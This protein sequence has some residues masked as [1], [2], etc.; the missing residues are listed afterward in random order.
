MLSGWLQA[1]NK[2]LTIMV[3]I[4]KVLYFLTTMVKVIQKNNHRTYLT[5]V[6]RLTTD[7]ANPIILSISLNFSYSSLYLN[8]QEEQWKLYSFT[9]SLKIIV[10][11]YLV[12]NITSFAKS[13]GKWVKTFRIF[14]L[15]MDLNGL[16][17]TFHSRGSNWLWSYWI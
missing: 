13:W 4:E 3:T 6:H 7:N 16:N 10:L 12:S 8:L 1:P 17:A 15:I 11:T 2:P 5:L 9:G 14:W